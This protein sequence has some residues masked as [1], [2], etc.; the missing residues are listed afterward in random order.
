MQLITHE[1]TTLTANQKL[2]HYENKKNRYNQN[3]YT[4]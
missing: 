2:A 3:G 4:Y 1:V